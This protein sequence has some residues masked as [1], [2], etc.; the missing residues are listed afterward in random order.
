MMST[1]LVNFIHNIRSEV[2]DLH[3]FKVSH[4]ILETHPEK[5]SRRKSGIFNQRKLILILLAQFSRAAMDVY[6]G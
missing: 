6:Q 1:N 4:I 5:E 3:L 2:T